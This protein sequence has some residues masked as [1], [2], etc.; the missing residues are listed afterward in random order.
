MHHLW[1]SNVNKS[2]VYRERMSKKRTDK[3]EGGGEGG[4]IIAIMEHPRWD[5]KNQ[6]INNRIQVHTTPLERVGL[7]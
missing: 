3:E 2:G 6:D 5:D 1:P 4:M 7:Q